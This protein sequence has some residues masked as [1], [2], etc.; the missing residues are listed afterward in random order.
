[1]GGQKYRRNFLVIS[2]SQPDTPSPQPTPGP[3]IKPHSAPPRRSGTPYPTSLITEEYLGAS[4]QI[5]AKSLRS[6]PNDQLTH[7]MAAISRRHR[8]NRG[9]KPGVLH[10]DHGCRSQDRFLLRSHQQGH[11]GL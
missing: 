2:T 9:R 7:G 8:D 10:T 6:C 3:R 4:Y 11:G 5:P 1:M